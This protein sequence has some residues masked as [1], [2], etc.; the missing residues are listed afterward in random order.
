[1]APEYYCLL[2][3][4]FKYPRQP[5][6]ERI[7]RWHPFVVQKQKL[8]F[9]IFLQP[10]EQVIAFL[11]YSLGG[12]ASYSSSASGVFHHTWLPVRILSMGPVLLSHPGCS[13]NG[14]SPDQ[15]MNHRSHI[16]F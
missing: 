14:A 11:K 13:G 6:T 8:T 1:M 9:L 3:L 15:L 5:L 10:P 2:L 12:I 4:P 7:V 16:I